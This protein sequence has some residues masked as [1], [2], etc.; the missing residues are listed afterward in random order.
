MRPQRWP[1][2]RTL[3]GR[4]SLAGAL[5][6]QHVASGDA[7]VSGVI[8]GPDDYDP[9]MWQDDL[10]DEDEELRVIANHSDHDAALLRADE[11]RLREQR[12]RDGI[13]E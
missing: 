8:F 3:V 2:C 13:A 4:W 6:G 9:S 12:K 7:D 11:R 1:R 5:D 10:T